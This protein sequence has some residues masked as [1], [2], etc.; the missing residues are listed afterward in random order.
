MS[1][2]FYAPIHSPGAGTFQYFVN[3]QW[4]QSTSGKT[5]AVINPTTREK[6]YQ[7][8]GECGRYPCCSWGLGTG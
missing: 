2:D 3:G 4:K 7:V 5:V 6:E 8:Q 1:G